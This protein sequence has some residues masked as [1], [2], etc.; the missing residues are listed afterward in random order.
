MITVFLWDLP[1]KK[2]TECRREAD[3]GR[4]DPR[5]ESVFFVISDISS[6]LL[7]ANQ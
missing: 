6:L 5:L 3:L 1:R 7:G 4:K 2:G